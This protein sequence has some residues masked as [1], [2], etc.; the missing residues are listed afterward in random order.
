MASANKAVLFASLFLAVVAWQRRLPS[1]HSHHLD[2]VFIEADVNRDGILDRNEFYQ[3][4]KVYDLNNDG[5]VTKH[6]YM[7]YNNVIMPHHSHI[8]EPMFNWY[9]TN[10]D[11][12]LNQQDYVTFFPLMDTNGDGL[13][14]E[15]EFDTYWGHVFKDHAK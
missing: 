5:N 10:K 13:V 12:Q 4:F 14:T 15:L 1:E 11:G 2:M 7:D 6:E 8:V 3:S 9:D